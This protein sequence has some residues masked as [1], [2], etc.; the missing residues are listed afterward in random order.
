MSVVSSV[1]EKAVV[2]FSTEEHCHFDD[3]FGHL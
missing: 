2:F 1:V 3:R